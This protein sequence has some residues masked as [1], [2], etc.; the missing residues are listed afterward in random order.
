VSVLQ[1]HITSLKTL[2]LD[3]PG[4]GLIFPGALG[5]EW[6][7]VE[8]FDKLHTLQS[9]RTPFHMLMGRPKCVRQQ[10]PGTDEWRIY[11]E[12]WAGFPR[13]RDVLPPKLQ[14]LKL[15]LDPDVIAVE[16]P[17]SCEEQELLSTA[18]P[19]NS[20]KSSSLREFDVYLNMLHHSEKLP[21]SPPEVSSWYHRTGVTF[22][23]MIHCDLPKE[24]QLFISSE[25]T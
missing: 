21:I 19:L 3:P 25:G 15:G 2:S 7:R 18:L 24:G 6:S 17:E 4:E 23:Y 10:Q 13:L 14:T 8:G 9:L 5:P 22:Q 16:L 20:D 11:P 1:H 12:D